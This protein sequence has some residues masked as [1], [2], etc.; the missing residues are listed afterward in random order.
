MISYLQCIILCF[1]ADV[2]AQ[3]QSQRYDALW[4]DRSS[5][6]F[7]LHRA[8]GAEGKDRDIQKNQKA[9]T[10]SNL[11]IKNSEF[12]KNSVVKDFSRV[13]NHLLVTHD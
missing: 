4:M 12:S 5:A 7:D 10:S 3:V 6:D 13:F 9:E 1:C 2:Q 11:A 8:E